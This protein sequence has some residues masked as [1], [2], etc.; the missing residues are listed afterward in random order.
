M[1]CGRRRN[2]APSMYSGS[3]PKLWVTTAL[4]RFA[5]FVSMS[6][7]TSGART[8]RAGRSG[9]AAA[10]PSTSAAVVP[11]AAQRAS[12][13]TRRA[14]RP[15]TYTAET[16]PA[17]RGLAVAQDLRLLGLELRLGEEALRLQVAGLLEPVD[18]V[19]RRRGACCASSEGAAERR[20]DLLRLFVRQALRLELLRDV[21]PAPR[22]RDRRRVRHRDRRLRGLVEDEVLRVLGVV[23]DR[24][25]RAHAERVHTRDE[26]LGLEL[27]RRRVLRLDLHGQLGTRRLVD[28]D[29]R[30]ADVG[31]C[32]ERRL[33]RARQLA[34]LAPTP[35]PGRTDREQDQADG[36][37]DDS[38]QDEPAADEDQ[39]CRARHREAP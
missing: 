1:S 38:H 19:G 32:R 8:N 31:Q 3:W 4:A 14:T 26:P 11:Q 35:N 15:A 9:S 12:I 21:A 10:G 36:D 6:V 5:G 22:D 7:F 37:P 27:E 29:A 16:V 28:R 39:D 34:V 25:R 18:G 13:E 2:A 30:V 33:P 20:L 24:V 17:A 23:T